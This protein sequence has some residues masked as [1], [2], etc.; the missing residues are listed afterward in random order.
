MLILGSPGEGSSGRG[1]INPL[2]GPR[3][4]GDMAIGGPK[5]GM[6]QRMS[7]ADSTPFVQQLAAAWPTDDWRD[8]TVIVAVSGGP[9]SVA[10]LRGLA[11]LKAAA[12][13]PGRLV[14]AHFN[15]GLRADA[16]DDARFV[17]ALAGQLALP[18]EIGGRDPLAK[19]ASDGDGVE[20]A[21]RRDRYAFLQRVS[22][23]SGARFV[24]TGH[25][26]DDQ[27][28]T[29]LFNILRGTG[30]AGLAGIPRV[31]LLSDAVSVIR[32][33]LGIG[34]GEVLNYL[35]AIGQA[36]R[37]DSTNASSDFTRNRIRNELLL[38]LREQ[39]NADVDSAITRLSRVASD[40]QQTIERLADDLL[41]RCGLRKSVSTDAIAIDIGKLRDCDRHVVREMFVI[42]WRQMN[43]PLQQIGFDECEM[44]AAMAMNDP[45]DSNVPRKREFPGGV[46]VERA[47][48]ELRLRRGS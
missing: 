42:L 9:D 29:V 39:F 33:M 41:E 8:V 7:T 27:V 15:H 36:H 17:A 35:V 11:T 44:L 3:V 38:L 24:A 5:F 34:R 28:E 30:L 26:A 12:V 20:A 46:M 37:T 2:T 22:R 14:V 10:L 48:G 31:R 47:D 4:R 19:T 32:P 43:W 25:T 23:Q 1:G 40:A 45:R 21:A 13:G 18:C 16:G 6:I